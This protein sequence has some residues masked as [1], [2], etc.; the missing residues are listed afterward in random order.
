M[1]IFLHADLIAFRCVQVRGSHTPGTP[2]QHWLLDNVRRE[3]NELDPFVKRR[4]ELRL[5]VPS[6]Q[7]EPAP[8][9]LSLLISAA[10]DARSV[11][12]STA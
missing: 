11:H 2:L 6:S 9:S 12:R 8:L 1:T 7:V 5:H 3:V 4:N 10:A